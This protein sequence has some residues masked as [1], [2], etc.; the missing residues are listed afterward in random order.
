VID[1]LQRRDIEAEVLSTDLKYFY[2]VKRELYL[3]PLLSVVVRWNGD[4]QGLGSWLQDLLQRTIY[5]NYEVIL[6]VDRE[7]IDAGLEEHL[8]SVDQPVRLVIADQ[9]AGLAAHYNH[10]LPHC[11]GDYVVCVRGDLDIDDGY[12]LSALV[13]YCQRPDAGIVA[14]RVEGDAIDVPEVTPIPE[15]DNDSPWYYAQFVQQA[16]ILLNG[17]HCP[18]NVWCPSWDCCA[19]NRD[20]FDACNGFD[21]DRFPDLFAMH[22][23][24]F[25][26]LAAGFKSILYPVLP[27]ASAQRQAIYPDGNGRV[28]EKGAAG[29]PG[30][31]AIGAGAGGS[32]LQPGEQLVRR[33]ST[34]RG[35]WRG[36]PEPF[37]NVAR[38]RRLGHSPNKSLTSRLNFIRKSPFRD[39]PPPRREK[40]EQIQ[41]QPF[42]LLTIPQPER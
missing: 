4:R 19:V 35:S 25:K 27:P 16:S 32:V 38:R 11:D 2:R 24:G 29:L 1:A 31:M 34:W 18:Q 14:G 10:A 30:P 6:I 3:L 12:W 17:L 8:L 7:I 9:P 13:E 20:L 15:I 36:L 40:I 5:T 42:S 22:D 23:L 26:C 28:V 37:P 39:L 33:E 21:A 41:G